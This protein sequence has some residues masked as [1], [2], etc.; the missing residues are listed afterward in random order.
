MIKLNTTNLNQAL[1]T[2]A[3]PGESRPDVSIDAKG[4][5][6]IYTRADGTMG[7]SGSGFSRWKAERAGL[8]TG[9]N[10]LRAALTR[11][12]I[13]APLADKAVE[14][15]ERFAETKAEADAERKQQTRGNW[16]DIGKV[17]MVGAVVTVVPVVGTAIGGTIMAVACC[18]ALGYGLFLTGRC[19][20]ESLR[21]P[22]VLSLRG[23]V[24]KAKPEPSL[25]ADRQEKMELQNQTAA[26][27]SERGGGMPAKEK[28]GPAWMLA[29]AENES[30]PEKKVD[31]LKAYMSHA[32]PSKAFTEGMAMMSILQIKRISPEKQYE[33]LFDY[34]NAHQGKV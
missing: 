21:K 14:S 3:T 29:N 26:L 5:K 4:L 23:E 28:A 15:L 10:A 19:I 25:V 33:L 13:D 16:K 8:A 12:G 17:A 20:Y 27:I 32:V 6:N 30:N 11:G 22:D 18:A 24:E 7:V 9:P 2:I 34:I 1:A 31:L